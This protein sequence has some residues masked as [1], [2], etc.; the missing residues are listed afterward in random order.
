MEWLGNA[1]TYT[2]SLAAR[3]I[4]LALGVSDRM[5]VSQVGNHNHCA[6]P[7]SQQPEVDAFVDKF[8]KG[9]SSVNT[10]VVKTDGSFNVDRARW[11]NWPTPNLR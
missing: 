9:A 8:L 1:S 7:A 5:G 11:I 2:T 3:E 6:F 10:N 4:W